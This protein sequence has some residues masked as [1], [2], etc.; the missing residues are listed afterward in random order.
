MIQKIKLTF[1]TIFSNTESYGSFS[2][3]LRSCRWCIAATGCIVHYFWPWTSA[4]RRQ[5][6]WLRLLRP[7]VVA[8]LMI[9]HRRLTFHKRMMTLVAS[10]VA[11]AA[12]Q[13]GGSRTDAAES[14]MCCS[15][16]FTAHFDPTED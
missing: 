10:M 9:P 12:H 4:R 5:L 11:A 7:F 14:P 6:W 3:I 1:S 15:C 16:D 8:F 13:R 2:D